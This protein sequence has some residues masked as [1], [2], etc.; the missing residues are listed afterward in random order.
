MKIILYDIFCDFGPNQ[1]PFFE[2]YTFYLSL[3]KLKILLSIKNSFT[4]KSQ[5]SKKENNE[6]SES[7]PKQQPP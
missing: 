4:Q 6:K 3:L 1:C 5:R 7:V 2:N